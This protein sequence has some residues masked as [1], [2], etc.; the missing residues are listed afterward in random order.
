MSSEET[1]PPSPRASSGTLLYE[2]AET[3][4]PEEAHQAYR[5]RSLL[6]RIWLFA[7]AAFRKAV[8]APGYI[9]SVVNGSRWRQLRRRQKVI[10]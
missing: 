2:E 3:V 9:L 1:V 10:I 7:I 4:F 6:R 5:W 8:A